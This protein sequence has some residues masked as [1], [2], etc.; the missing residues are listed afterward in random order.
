MPRLHLTVK[1]GETLSIPGVGKITVE[2]KTGQRTK[3]AIDM[4]HQHKVELIQQQ[5]KEPRDWRT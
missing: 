1:V 2:H 3:L 4:E 5:A